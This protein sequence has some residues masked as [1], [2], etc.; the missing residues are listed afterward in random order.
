MDRNLHIRQIID[1]A[2]LKVRT[3]KGLTN[4]D[5]ISQYYRK[6]ISDTL[7]NDLNASM[8]TTKLLIK[9]E[10]PII[11][12]I[13]DGLSSYRHWSYFDKRLEIEQSDIKKIIP[14]LKIYV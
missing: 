14:S 6:M 10:A 4:D 2:I 5:H 3:D 9:N 11:E 8:V 1:A 7:N 12:Q 13:R